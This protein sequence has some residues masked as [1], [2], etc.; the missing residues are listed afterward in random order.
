MLMALRPRRTCASIHGRW[1]SQAET[2]KAGGRGGGFWGPS[3]NFPAGKSVATPGDFD[4]A[5]YR[6]MV[7]RSTPVTRSISRWLAPFCSSVCRVIRKCDFK[8]FNSSRSFKMEQRNVP[9]H[10]CRRTRAGGFNSD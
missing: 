9:S 2:A 3:A 8:T 5:A 6:R 1:A 7:L 10:H 4:I